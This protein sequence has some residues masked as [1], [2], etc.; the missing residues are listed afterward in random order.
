M[1]DTHKELQE[2]GEWTAKNLG[3]VES[4]TQKGIT[5]VAANAR[6]GKKQVWLSEKK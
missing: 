3:D 5:E 4:E 6:E 1:M 2:L